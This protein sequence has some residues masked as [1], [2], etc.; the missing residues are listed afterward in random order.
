M[1]VA[2]LTL[3]LMVAISAGAV[4]PVGS[5]DH[6]APAA[7]HRQDPKKPPKPP[8][9]PA[10]PRP[11]GD[12]ILKRRKPPPKPPH[13]PPEGRDFDLEVANGG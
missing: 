12:P 8:K 9:K 5:S 7:S 1:M 2:R 13:H 11:T 3:A 6:A 4:P 10:D